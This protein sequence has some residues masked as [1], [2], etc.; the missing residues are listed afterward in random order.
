VLLGAIGHVG[1]GIVLT[2]MFANNSI[3]DWAWNIVLALGPN[4]RRMGL[5]DL[6]R[7]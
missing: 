6:C 3:R 7:D 4:R 2:Q 5:L 1:D